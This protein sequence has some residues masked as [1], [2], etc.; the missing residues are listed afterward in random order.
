MKSFYFILVFCQFYLLSFPALAK[1]YYLSPTGKNSNA[2]TSLSNP[3]Q[4]ISKINSKTFY[5]DT[6]LFQGGITFTGS[7]TFNAS[8]KGTSTKPIVISSYGNGRAI[9]SS[10]NSYGIYIYN[11][12]AFKIENLIFTGAGGTVNNQTGILAYLDKDSTRLPYINIDSVEVYGFGNSGI[13]IGSWNKSSGY[14]NISITNSISHDNGG[15]AGIFIYAQN[16]YVHKN[17]YI[18]YNKTYNNT[19]TASD[20]LTNTG[21]GI[22]VTGVDGAV[23]EYCTSYNN[24]ELHSNAKGGPVGIWSAGSNNV[25]IQFNESHHNKTGTILDGGGFDFD[26]GTTNSILQYNYSH[27]NY[28]P[29]FMLFQSKGAPAMKNNIIRYNI[30]EN[31]VQKNSNGKYGAMYVGSATSDA[32]KMQGME[33]YNNTVYLDAGTNTK[34]KAFHYKSGAFTG[35]NVR[36][37]IFQTTNGAPLVNIYKTTGINFHGNCY[38]SSGSSFKITKADT[39]VYSSLSAFRNATGKEKLNGVA[40]GFQI[41]PKFLDS[42]RGV[43]FSDATQLANLST[44]KL[45]STSGL[46][47][48][49]KNLTKLFGLNV[50]T[51]DFW[52]N[53]ITNDTLFNV[54]AYQGIT[55]ALRRNIDLDDDS[56]E[57]ELKQ[58]TFQAFPNPFTLNAKIDFALPKAATVNILLYNFE[59]KIVRSLFSGIIRAGEHKSLAFNSEGLSAGAYIV[60]MV[61]D[62]KVLLQKIIV[63]Q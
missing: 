59:G 47:N 38:W 22:L 17:V 49:G 28:G 31:D 44:Y 43:T 26:G 8:D 15:K 6:I 63:K 58:I 32:S 3:W 11:T 4:T 30:S 18:G 27:D 42:V 24:G 16:Y 19:G 20:T 36:N 60:R 13:T 33:I 1:T 48:K 55:T 41:D 7:M 53:D 5:G 2:G 25:I 61:S 51:R 39:V 35:V 29:G 21:S 57:S 45:Q 52:G 37:N 50:G 54:G 12:G 34:A 40:C 10:G 56:K 9:I 23:V 46:I 14:D 62:N